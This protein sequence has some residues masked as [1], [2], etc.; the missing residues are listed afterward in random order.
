MALLDSISVLC[1]MFSPSE[2]K[3]GQFLHNMYQ[4]DPSTVTD[5]SG[6]DINLILTALYA[7]Q[8]GWASTRILSNIN[9]IYHCHCPQI[10][11]KTPNLPPSLP[12]GSNTR[13]NPG[14][15][16]KET[17]KPRTRTDTCFILAYF[18]I[19][20][21][22]WL[23]TG[24]LSLTSLTVWPGCNILINDIILLINKWTNQQTHAN[25]NKASP[26]INTSLHDG[27]D[28]IRYDTIR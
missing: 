4:H 5:I 6:H 14:S 9:P 8:P 12:L 15:Q 7:A 1:S 20:W 27:W 22:S 23:I 19:W 2:A 25:K 10:P 3:C 28:G 16:L 13:E 24:L 26:A 11:H 17:K 18:W 21:G